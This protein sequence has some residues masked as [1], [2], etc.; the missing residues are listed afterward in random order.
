[1]LLSLWAICFATGLAF[2]LLGPVAGRIGVSA[3]AWGMTGVAFGAGALF[4]LGLLLLAARRR[5]LAGCLVCLGIGVALGAEEASPTPRMAAL[6]AAL[7]SEGATLLEATW[8][9]APAPTPAGGGLARAE[10]ALES[11][12]GAPAGGRLMLSARASLARFWP[13]DRVRFR[14]RLRESFG[15]A[16]PGL[17]D[18]RL[19]AKARGSALR[20][21]V[22][23]PERIQILATGGPSPRRWA[24]G[25][26][27]AL[28]AAID[29]AVP[30][31]R[32]GLLRALVLGERTAGGEQVELGF[33]AAGAVHALSV[34][35]LH[36]TAVAAVFFLLLRRAIL[37]LPALALR[38][39]PD[40]LAAALAIPAVLFYTLVSGEAVA[41]GRAA[42]MASVGFG[43]LLVR[44]PPC[45]AGAIALAGAGLLAARPALLVDPSFQ[46]SVASVTALALCA[47][48]VRKAGKNTPGRILRWVKQGIF[49]TAVAFVVTAP[50]CAHHFA[51]LAPAAPLGNLLLV[52]PVELAIVPLGLFGS[53]LG[54]LAPPVGALPLFAADLLCRLVLVLAEGFRR[55]APLLKVMSPTGFEALLLLLGALLALW[56]WPRPSH[57]RTLARWVRSLALLLVTVGAG[58]MGH[59]VIDRWTREGLGVTFLDVGQGDA[60]LIEGPRGFVALVDGGGAIPG[61]SGDF[62]PG[63]RVIEPVLRR[64]GIFRIDLVILSHPHPDHMNGLFHVLESFAVSALWTA[65]SDGG[66]PAFGRLL[67]LAQRRDTALAR[68]HTVVRNGL[69]IEPWGPWLDGEIRS[70]P[71]LSPNDA[72]L[73]VRVGY[74]GRH[75]F[76]AGDLEVQGEAELVDRAAARR[77]RA[78]VLKL[79]HHGSRTSSSQALLEAVAPELVAMSLGRA[80][81]FGFPHAEVLRRLAANRLPVFRTD[82]HGAVTIEVSSDGKISTTCALGCR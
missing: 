25:A 38:L 11:V 15:L 49:L 51:L 70:P 76:F 77:P 28:G 14:A 23:R 13:G 16:N 74:R 32:N 81:R 20:A 21:F 4:V 43:A 46:L 79:P 47:P 27:L 34:S 68:P 3:G 31:P 40:L 71:G 69:S 26:R 10:L 9:R 75:V 66:N 22:A 1:M 78:Q 57:P 73:V 37:L 67:A 55:W 17:P 64:K 2:G 18:P 80:N 19:A 53:A 24:H 45:P 41:T 6:D 62:D 50:L 65:G 44:R 29:A 12:D 82:R 63:A 33:R 61:L 60:A 36:L 39:H 58:S 59:R 52:P 30:P 56:A 8:L 7:H 48:L 72:S 5:V 42:I 35:G 54:A